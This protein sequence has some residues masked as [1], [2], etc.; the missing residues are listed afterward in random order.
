MTAS[1]VELANLKGRAQLLRGGRTI[2]IGARSEGRFG[3]DPMQVL[4]H[5]EPFCEWAQHIQPREEDAVL[6]PEQLGP[7][8]PAP[9]QIFAIGLNYK[10]HA[11]EAA[12]P[13]PKEPVVF[14]KFQSALA[15]P[16]ADIRLTSLRVDWEIELVIVM[17]REGR[18]IASERALDHVAG[19]TVG[20]DISDRRRQFMDSPPQFSLGKSARGYAPTGP[21]VVALSGLSD[22]NDLTLRCSINGEQVQNGRTRE[23]IFP[24]PEVVSYLSKWCELR[25][26]DLVFTGTPAGV[27]AVRTPR[28]YLAPSDI[29]ESEIEGIGLLRNRCRAP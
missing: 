8:V 13:I 16:H 24:V 23:M 22:P 12:L 14:T 20:Q 9:S 15:G 19:F 21:A 17:G 29:I 18:D 6:A 26:G 10:D 4:Q 27:G 3:P 11:L 28:R 25:P 7:P 1:G 2:D 5:W